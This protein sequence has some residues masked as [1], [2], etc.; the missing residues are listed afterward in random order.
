[1]LREPTTE[2]LTTMSNNSKRPSQRQGVP[3]NTSNHLHRLNILSW[4]I[5]D[6]SGTQ[7]KKVEDPDFLTIINKANIFCLQETKE[8][9]KI[10]NFRCF[11]S[12]RVDSRSGGVCLGIQNDL[13]QHLQTL[14]TS[15]FSNDFQAFLLSKRLL[16]LTRDL[17]IINIY[18]SPPNSSY[19][20]KKDLDGDSNSTLSLVDEFC[21]GLPQDSLFFI[22]GDMNARTGP[23][24]AITGREHLVLQDLLNSNSIND[25]QSLGAG[26][27]VSK[28]TVTNERGNKLLDFGCAWN[29]SIVNGSVLG[30]SL[31][32]WTCYRYNGS[33]VVDYIMVS[34]TLRDTISY[35]KVLELTDHSD[36]RPLLCSMCISHQSDVSGSGNRNFEDKPLG[37]KWENQQNESKNKF[38]TAQQQESITI[39]MTNLCSTNCESTD[40]V[41]KLNDELTGIFREIANSSLEK[42]RRPRN[43]RRANKKVWFDEE[44]RNVKRFLGKLTR[45]YS[46][47]PENE[48]TRSDFYQ[49]KKYYRSI[50]KFKKRCYYAQLNKDIEEGNEINWRNFKKLKETKGDPDQLDLHDLSNFH[51]FFKQLYSDSPDHIVIPPTADQQSDPA[52]LELNE[53][54]LNKDID[55]DELSRAIYKL[56]MG[57]AVGEDC[58]P[59]EFLR[60]SNAGLR[61]SILHLFNQCLANGVYPWNV[62]L[63]T[64]LHKKGDRANPDNYRAIAVSSAIGKLFSNILLE[65]YKDYKDYKIEC[66]IT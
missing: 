41:Y 36:H 30:D 60:Y 65:D 1:M 50:L 9:I 7:G 13:C 46:R 17:V 8:E 40:E 52:T 12:N 27:R 53:E 66:L 63:V 61:L 37:F 39:R 49:T 15:K 18:D 4:N 29:L 54:L 57:K 19:K 3:Y 26:K 32:D 64:P 31:G 20:M 16:G 11:N 48:Q 42:R 28:D 25:Q 10:P 24:N 58:V 38:L 6:A 62:S 22:A 35:L 2:T 47:D 51:D 59:N 23:N 21:S 33:S 55:I 5:H 56:K 43:T 45:K 34:H 44:C 14:N